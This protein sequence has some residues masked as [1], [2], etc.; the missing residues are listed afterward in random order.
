MPESP[1]STD[2][3]ID[4]H[5]LNAALVRRHVPEGERVIV[6]LRPSSLFVLLARWRVMFALGSIGAGVCWFDALLRGDAWSGAMTLRLFIL[7]LALPVTLVAAYNAVDRATRLYLLTDRRAL[8]VSGIIRQVVIDAPL[9]RVQ[10]AAL[11]ARARER[12]L[13]L[14]TPIIATAGSEAGALAWTMIERPSEALHVLRH[15]I[16][17][18]RVSQRAASAEGEP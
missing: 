6:A 4:R 8:R 5:A 7:G 11:T 9:A 16:D 10:S 1:S 3:L 12:L 15:E 14:G 17:R 18:A 2:A 13:G